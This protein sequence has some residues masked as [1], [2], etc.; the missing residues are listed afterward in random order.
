MA[1]Q[2]RILRIAMALSALSVLI[3]AVGVLEL[4]RS[5]Y[6][7][8]I[9]LTT[10]MEPTVPRYSLILAKKEPPGWLQTGDIA[11]YI[12]GPK[13]LPVM[14]RIIGGDIGEG[15]YYIKGDNVRNIEKVDFSRIKGVYVTGVYFGL[16]KVVS[17]LSDPGGALIASLA[18]TTFIS[19]ILI[20]YLEGRYRRAQ[21][22]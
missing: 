4:V 16:D 10:S 13:S 19:I 15:Y 18:L 6:N 11:V 9:I 7:F 17:F 3:F 20:S 12:I 1:S 5:N 2:R 14:H 21:H 8:Y 22:E